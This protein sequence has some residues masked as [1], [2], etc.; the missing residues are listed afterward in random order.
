MEQSKDIKTLADLTPDGENF[1]KH[2]EFG[3]KL[4]EDSLRKFGAGRSILVDKD[5]NIIAGN[6]TDK[7]TASGYRV[8][9][10]LLNAYNMGVP[11]YR[12]RT[13][14]IGLRS[15]FNL[16]RLTLSFN[17]P[18]IVFGEIKDNSGRPIVSEQTLF[19]W[20]RRKQGDK[21]LGD[22][23]K[24]E[25]G[26]DCRYTELLLHDDE[27]CGT[28]ASSA[29]LQHF[30]EPLHVSDSEILKVCTFPV[31]YKAQNVKFY[32]G[33]SVPPVMCA[34]IANQIYIQWLSKI[35]DNGN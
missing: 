15:D 27:V 18:Q 32:C 29:M 31:D 23:Y 1:N 13:F 19:L 10:F 28:I 14:F 25:L 22:I 26:K 12:P 6:S 33:M 4:L 17:E 2:T 34:Q 35:E 16:P 3:T 8:Q 21:C 20:Q 5:G 11:S 7:L 24:R 30:S 9:V